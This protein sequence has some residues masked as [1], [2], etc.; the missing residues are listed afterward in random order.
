MKN[1]TTKEPTYI[2]PSSYSAKARQYKL[3]KSDFRK[4]WT[5]KGKERASSED[6]VSN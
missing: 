3:T 4:M 2:K 1:L 5:S 6:E